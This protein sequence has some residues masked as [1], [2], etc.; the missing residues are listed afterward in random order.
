M[1]TEP[2]R[3][4]YCWRVAALALAIAA[5]GIIA[6]AGVTHLLGYGNSAGVLKGLILV[7]SCFTASIL[8]RRLR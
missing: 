1:S 6:Q 8:V 2:R 5:V 3:P 4:G 7:A